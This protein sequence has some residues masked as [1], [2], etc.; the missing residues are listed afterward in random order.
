MSQ[1]PLLLRL[2]VKGRE[3]KLKRTRDGSELSRLEIRFEE[4]PLFPCSNTHSLW[5]EKE[6]SRKY[7]MSKGDSGTKR[8][9][10]RGCI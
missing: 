7:H 2:T 1:R 9:K 3:E 4:I 5:G 10:K 6:M 8:E